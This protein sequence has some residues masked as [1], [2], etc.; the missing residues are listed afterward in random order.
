MS[1][2]LRPIKWECENDLCHRWMKA[3]RACAHSSCFLFSLSQYE[4][5][6]LLGLFGSQTEGKEKSPQGSAVNTD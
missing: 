3:V 2:L 6:G 5:T 4:A 1:E